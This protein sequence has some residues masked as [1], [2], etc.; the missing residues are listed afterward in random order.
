MGSDGKSC[1]KWT[2]DKYVSTT[3]VDYNKKTVTVTKVQDCV[4]VYSEKKT[5]THSASPTTVAYGAS[6]TPA[7][8]SNNAT[9]IWYELYEKVHVV[10]YE[11]CMPFANIDLT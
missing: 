4:T 1:D 11:V 8:S 7:V 9:G 3:I 5:I 2:E 10:E 6:T